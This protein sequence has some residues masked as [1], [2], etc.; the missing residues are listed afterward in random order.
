MNNALKPSLWHRKKIFSSLELI[1]CL[2]TLF[3]KKGME[4]ISN[5]CSSG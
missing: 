4:G 1:S 5:Q 2:R 3:I